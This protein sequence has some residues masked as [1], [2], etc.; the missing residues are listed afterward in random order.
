MI[1]GEALHLTEAPSGEGVG[2]GESL[3]KRLS[4]IEKYLSKK[5]TEL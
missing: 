3:V 5:I 2:G 1:W 4:L